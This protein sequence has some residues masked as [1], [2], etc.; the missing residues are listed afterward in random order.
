MA[1]SFRAGAYHAAVSFDVILVVVA[2]N[3][4]DVVVDL[5]R[6]VRPALG[7]T[8]AKVVVVDNGSSDNTV[9]VVERWAITEGGSELPVQ[10]VRSCNAGYAAGVNR[11]VEDEGSGAPILVLNPDVRLG[12]GSVSPM[13]AALAR[14]HV[15]IVVP[16]IMNPGGDRDNS[17]RRAPSLGRAC[18]LGFTGLPWLSE[19][20]T[21]ER[22][23]AR[24]HAVDWATGAA[25]L[26]RHEVHDGLGGWDESYFLYSE[27]TDFCAR[28]ADVGWVTLFEPA[29]VVQHIG[30]A[31]GRTD[32]THVMQ[33]V[34]RVRFYARA[35]SRASAGLYLLFTV[36]SEFSWMLR[37][38]PYARASIK[39]LL[40]PSARPPELGCS[41]GL[42]PL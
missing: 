10:V 21:D 28:A 29:S 22:A 33:I 41:E 2:Y 34:N 30:G 26:V 7:G 17:L 42:I 1:G 13:L 14:P 35:H 24:R 16:L 8:T 27:E 25:M 11:G 18:G 5:L 9:E 37:G 32:R 23:Y 4:A 20:V 39:A 31:S 6:S 12:P 40:L 15:G 19:Y 3:S 38:H 36:A